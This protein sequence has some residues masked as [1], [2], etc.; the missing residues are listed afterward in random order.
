ML[1]AYSLSHVD[2]KLRSFQSY[3]RWMCVDQSNTYNTIIFWFYFLTHRA[4]DMVV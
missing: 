1:Y 4:Y 3:L 2:D